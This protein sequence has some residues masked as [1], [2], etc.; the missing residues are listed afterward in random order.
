MMLPLHQA[1]VTELSR[2]GVSDGAFTLALVLTRVLDTWSYRSFSAYAAA[3]E[4]GLS[5]PELT[6]A[7][8]ELVDLGALDIRKKACLGRWMTL[9]R[10]G[11]AIVS[12]AAAFAELTAPA[13][14]D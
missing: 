12:R 14:N 1:F 4:S 2:M 6:R 13:I 9:Y 10:L 8:K 11:K 3:Q 5:Q 7:V